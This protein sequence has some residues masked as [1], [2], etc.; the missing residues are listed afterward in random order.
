VSCENINDINQ[1]DFTTIDETY[2]SQNRKYLTGSIK[3]SK[4]RNAEWLKNKANSVIVF[5]DLANG[6]NHQLEELE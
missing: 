1:Q 2:N 6:E 5:Q 4:L 3:F